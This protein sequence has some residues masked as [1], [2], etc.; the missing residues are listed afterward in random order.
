MPLLLQLN[1]LH[2]NPLRVILTTYRCLVQNMGSYRILIS[3]GPS[4]SYGSSRIIGG[5]IE[6][7]RVEEV[8]SPGWEVV[9]EVEEN[10][11]GFK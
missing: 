8:R 10:R 4:L 1:E 5:R 11:K 7:L 3:S 9:E 2:E 6:L